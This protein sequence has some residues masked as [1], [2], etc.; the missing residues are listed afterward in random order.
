M[1]LASTCLA[2]KAA[3]TK[4]SLEGNSIGSRGLRAISEALTN[5]KEL[6]EI[7]LYNNQIEDDGIDAFA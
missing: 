7:Y 6:K 3:L 4:L 2:D 1:H 5:S